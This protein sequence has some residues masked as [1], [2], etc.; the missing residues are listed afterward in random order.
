MDQVQAGS[1]TIN[2]VLQ[3]DCLELLKTLPD[4]SVDLICT[5]PP[6]FKVKKDWWDNQWSD[7]AK[8]LDWMRL[9]A[10]E[11]QRVLK[12]NGS[13]YCFASARMAAKVEVMLGE[14]FNVLNR[15][16]WEKERDRG[17]HAASCK[18]T[19]RGYFPNTESIIF[20][21]H[22]G[23]D[24]I[25]KGEAGYQ[26][27]CDELRGFVF[28]PLRAWFQQE[29]IKAGIT[30]HNQVN[31]ALG[32]KTG[33]GGMAS[34]YFGKTNQWELPTHEHSPATSPA[35]TKTYARNTKTYARNT[36]PYAAPSASRQM[37]PIRM[38]GPS[39]RF[40]LTPASTVA[41]SLPPCL[42]TSSAP[43]PAPVP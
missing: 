36:N 16:T 35:S 23:A 12:P 20:C 42:S 8:F 15:I 3:G 38:S 37:F 11:W 4:N 21:E 26:A 43:A 13:L 10:I 29:R 33:G 25:A 24:N 17:K 9:L 32:L 22:Y 39:P 6:Y 2:Q 30:K 14:Q 27:K 28:E 5:D 34:H 19:L 18:E 1:K 40:R 41:R 7:P 31:S